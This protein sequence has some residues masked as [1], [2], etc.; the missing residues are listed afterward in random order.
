M[1]DHALN[2]LDKNQ[3]I[4]YIIHEIPRKPAVIYYLRWTYPEGQLTKW[5]SG[6]FS[7]P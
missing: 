5:Y 2:R 4:A 6:Y 1:F 7:V 3:D